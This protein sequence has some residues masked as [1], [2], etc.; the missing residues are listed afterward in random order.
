MPAPQGPHAHLYRVVTG[1]WQAVLWE[2][3]SEEGEHQDPKVPSYCEPGSGWP[4]TTFLLRAGGIINPPH[5]P[6]GLRHN[7]WPAPAVPS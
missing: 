6:E 5:P 2:E 3:G 4:L 1:G 7:F